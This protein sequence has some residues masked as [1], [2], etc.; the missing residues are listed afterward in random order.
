MLRIKDQQHFVCFPAPGVV[1]N[2]A[3]QYVR[4]HGTKLCLP[5]P[6]DSGLAGKPQECFADQCRRLKRMIN[7]FVL[8]LACGDLSQFIVNQRYQLMN[9]VPITGRNAEQ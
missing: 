8:Q 6:V 2:D 5:V 4:G 9:C 1:H 3:P 7:A